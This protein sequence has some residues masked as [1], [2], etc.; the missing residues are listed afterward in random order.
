[1]S[2]KQPVQKPRAAKRKTGAGKTGANQTRRRGRGPVALSA[3]LPRIAGRALR[4]RG[5]AEAAIVTDWAAIVGDVLARETVPRKLVF[6]RGENTGGTLHVLVSGGFSTELQ[7]LA[8]LVTE[9]INAYFGYAAVARLTMAQ[10]PVAP[11]A[12]DPPRN[13]RK[14]ARA[15]SGPPSAALAE[16]LENIEDPEL[17]ASLIR[18]GAILSQDSD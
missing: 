1:M 2:P 4:R 6:P 7:H 10:G 12:P 11:A 13:R 16:D 8:P 5:F 18:F 15:P 14:A 3:L 9:K 17:R